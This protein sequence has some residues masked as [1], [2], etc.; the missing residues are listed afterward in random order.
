M[1]K[2]YSGFFNNSPDLHCEIINR[3]VIGNKV[4]DQEKVTSNGSSFGAIAIY[5]IENG[6]ISKVTFLQ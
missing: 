6:L 3:I 1:R 5:E 2:G 4:I